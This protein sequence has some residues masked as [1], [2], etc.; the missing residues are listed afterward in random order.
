[1]AWGCS[2]GAASAARPYSRGTPSLPAQ[3]GREC[4]AAQ[5]VPAARVPQLVGLRCTFCTP[6][7]ASAG[8][9]PGARR[10]RGH[11]HGTTAT[12]GHS[13]PRGA[14]AP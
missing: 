8:R 14:R 13:A 2:S 9:A 12:P 1:M 5:R 10:L 6:A 7:P 3:G 11:H 4:A